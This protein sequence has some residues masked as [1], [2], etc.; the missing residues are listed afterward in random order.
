[1][2]PRGVPGREREARDA[3]TIMAKSRNCSSCFGLDSDALHF[4]VRMSA[5]FTLSS[6]F[7][8]AQLPDDPHRWP[9][10]IWLLITALLVCWLW[11][12]T[13]DAASQVERCVQHVQGTVVG[14]AFGM[15]CGVASLPVD[16]YL[17][18]R[19]QAAFLATCIAVVTFAM[20]VYAG[21][22]RIGGG[23]TGPILIE[24]NGYAT[25]ICVFTFACVL[26][27]FYRKDW[28]KPL[29]LLMNVGVGC[30]L[31]VAIS[32]GLYPRPTVSIIREKIE[33]QVE[34]A[35]EACEAVLHT[36]ADVF[37][38]NA[39]VRPVTLAEAILED[40]IAE[41]K[42]T[43]LD[44]KEEG[45][46]SV[47][48][49]RG[50]VRM[51]LGSMARPWRKQRPDGDTP[52]VGLGHDVILEKHAEASAEY[53]ATKSQLAMLSYDPFSIG[54]D[55][56]LL[57]KYKAEVARTLARSTRVQT[58]VVL[59]DGIIRNDPKHRFSKE[60]LELLAEVGGL[61]RRM[62]AV[63]LDVDASNA[64]MGLLDVRLKAMRGVIL[65]LTA[66]VAS[67]PREQLPSIIPRRSLAVG[68]GGGAIGS[69]SDDLAGLFSSTRMRGP[70]VGEGR[71]EEAMIMM[72]MDDD[73]DDEGG[74]GVLELVH[75]SHVCSLLF[76]QLAEH[77]AVR[78][79]R[80]YQSWK[81]YEG[82]VERAETLRKSMYGGGDTTAGVGVV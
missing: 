46:S 67:S 69:S 43:S 73:N 82:V 7:I 27:P 41:K 80:L 28:H 21:H 11:L 35:G 58:T 45:P 81:Q 52:H 54:R 48:G 71:E 76:L 39:Y 55:D 20:L 2:K 65:E 51:R 56:I 13:L 44:A 19:T 34:L 29:Y 25:L 8:L 10:G 66:T 5:C 36:A 78:S 63:P 24:K 59:I 12:P 47:S 23:T 77:L 9:L 17:G 32:V 38:E 62:L 18:Y 33:R 6:L 37:A 15:A 26:M 50:S 61:V 16:R 3:I 57:Q 75:G 72:M 70:V 22:A 74:M 30:A 68:G 4:G 60:N 31:G 79:V 49:F 42:K 53:G 1:M 64:A 14:A 40:C